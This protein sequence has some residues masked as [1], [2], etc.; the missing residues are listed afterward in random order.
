MIGRRGGGP[1]RKFSAAVCD[2]SKCQQVADHYNAGLSN[3]TG[4]SIGE[5][6]LACG[7]TSPAVQLRRASAAS[8]Q[9]SPQNLVVLICVLSDV[10]FR[11]AFNPD[12]STRALGACS[13]DASSPVLELLQL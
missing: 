5:G 4:G 2:V 10:I 1:S 11:M 9:L 6:V 8:L 13:V 3:K 7:L 12:Q